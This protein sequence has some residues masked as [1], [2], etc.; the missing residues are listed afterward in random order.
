MRKLFSLLFVLLLAVTLA[1]AS[2]W[3][4]LG[5]DGGDARSLAFDPH[6][7]DRI[8]LG[9]SSGQLYMSND[10][11]HSWNRFAQ[12]GLGDDYVLDNTAFD[13]SD[14]NTIY[15]GVWSVEHQRDAGDLYV[16]RDGGKSWKT[17]EGMRGK[18]IRALSIAPSNSKTLVIGALDGVYRSDD[19]GETWRRISPE[20]H[21]EIKNIESI[22][23][24]PK[25][26]D[27]V[28]A[29]TW[30]LPWK[31]DDGGKSWHH[32]KEGVIDDSDVF[33]IIVDFSNPSTVFASACSGIYKSESA[34]N[35]F[36]KVTG[37]PATARRT[38]VLMQDPKNPQIVY[39]G[40]TE[41]L[42]KTLDGGKTFKRMTGPE[43]I[44]NDVSVDPRD[45]SR[46][47]LATDRSGVLAS[48]NGGATFTQS[49]R[50]YSHRQV[51]SLLV[52]SKDPNTIYVGLLN[53]RDFGGMYVSR[54]AGSTWSQASKGL[55]DRDVFTLR[56]A[57]DGDIF[58]GTNHGVMK[59]SSKTLLWE[60]ASVV[61]KEKT[62]PGPKIP[63]KVVK[64]KKIP[65]HE[66]T[67]KVTIEKSELTS[68]VSQLVF[69][70]ALWYAAASSGVYSSKDDGKTWQHADIEGDVR[71]LAIGAFG[72][73]AFA[74]SA[75]DGYVTTDHGGHWTQVSVPKFITGI[76]DAAVG[77]D[78]SL[79]LA[80]QQGALRSGD[81]GKTWEHVTAGLPWK[82]VL[83]VSLDTANNRMLAT[84]RDGRGVYSSSDNGQTWKYSDDAGLLVRSAVGY[85]GGY[86]AA[87]AYNGVAISSAPGH[88]ATAPSASGSGNSN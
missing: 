65:A 51:S 44:V 46:V 25:N 29:G 66:G 43:V 68:Q 64:G 58:A 33:S 57:G 48:E 62:T 35:L 23:I 7:P 81:D 73:K 55:K 82:H 45:T 39:A 49:N 87:T 74:A 1:S 42:Y 20:N 77:F 38:R 34:G 4:E 84:S 52:D 53:D 72:D 19:S 37:I 69:T 47:L 86:L 14:P 36:H 61:V 76:Y 32:I 10:R 71:F 12:I 26:P 63:A 56:Q 17:I 5:P 8:L 70:P 9:T 21:A 11:G 3:K 88:S 50:G 2:S 6:N 85:R 75:L 79:W 41:G 80:T 16:T 40:T 22:A 27:V 15:I 30:H 18:S 78:Q 28:Y 31:T 67:P 54:D 13:P 24:D 60:P 83:T 59:F